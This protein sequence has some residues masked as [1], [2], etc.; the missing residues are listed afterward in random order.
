MYSFS[1]YKEQYRANL[2]LALPVVLSQVGQILVQ[3]ADNAMVGQFG[4]DDPL[5]LAAVSFGGAVFFILF[6][7]GMGLTLGL[8]PLVGERFAQGDKRGAADYLKNAMIFYSVLG[9]LIAAVQLAVIPLMYRMGQPAEVVDLAIPY[10]RLMAFSMP[11]VMLFFAF[12]QFLEGVGNTVVSM[13]IVVGCNLMNVVLNWVFIFGHCGFEAMGATGAGVATLISR[14]A[15]PLVAIWY[16]YRRKRLREYAALLPEVRYSRRSVRQL[17]R[18]GVPIS[19]QMFLE[20]S[21]FVLTSIMMGVVRRRGHQRQPDRADDGQ[22]RLHDRHG[23]RRG[24]DDP[25]FALLRRAAVRR[26]GPGGQGSA[27][28]RHRMEPLRRCGVRHFTADDSLYFHHQRRGGVACLVDARS[29]RSLPTAGRHPEHLSRGAARRAG[30][31]DHHA[32]GVGRLLGAEPAGGVSVRVHA[33]AG[34]VGALHRL[35][36]G[37]DDGRRALSAAHPAGRADATAIRFGPPVA[38]PS[39]PR[40]A[41]SRP[42]F[43]G[44]GGKF[45]C[46]IDPPCIESV[47]PSDAVDAS[48]DE[49]QRDGEQRQNREDERQPRALRQRVEVKV[50]MLALTTG[51]CADAA[52][53]FFHA[54]GFFRVACV[55]GILPPSAPIRLQK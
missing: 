23:R 37:A 4:G 30:R 7:T 13:V 16:F 8:T 54:F 5:P 25:Y 29:D 49:E 26:T 46:R 28:Y 17:V 53:V 50:E 9:F 22:F 11:A 14:I 27:A 31:E 36:R 34:A 3:F 42:R 10:Y 47:V 52:E 32:A 40:S 48:A 38:R 24:D 20:A 41:A 45:P 51:P 12:K 43:W 6:V 15:M 35:F 55:R 44:G 39:E 19:G 33:G 21:A 1:R 2:K 18:M